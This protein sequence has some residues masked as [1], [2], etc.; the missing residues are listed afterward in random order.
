MKE[1]DTSFP[2]GDD[3]GQLVGLVT[4]SDIRS[5]D[6]VEWSEHRVR[7]I[8]TPADDLE[9]VTVDTPAH[10]AL[11]TLSGRD[12]RQLPVVTESGEL[13]G[14][15]RRRDITKWLQLH[16]DAISADDNLQL[17]RQS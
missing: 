13:A 7:D 4:M 17:D 16:S 5:V 9:T 12:V 6:R 1:D 14:L 2:V 8:M 15:L 3:A 10:E 11:R